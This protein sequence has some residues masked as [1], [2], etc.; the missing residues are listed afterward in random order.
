LAT[1]KDRVIRQYQR[2]NRT[3][4]IPEMA[5][6]TGIPRK[7]LYSVMSRMVK[8]GLLKRPAPTLYQSNPTIGVGE[9]LEPWRIQNLRLIATKM[10]GVRI[11]PPPELEYKPKVGYF[12]ELV[13]SGLGGGERDEVRLQF[14]I[15]S[16][17]GKLTF[18]AK[19]PLG[20]DLYGLQFAMA[21]L[22][23]ECIEHGFG[24]KL[25]WRADRH[26]EIFKD[27]RVYDMDSLGA[28]FVSRSDY[29]GWMEKVYQKKYGAW[30]KEVKVPHQTSLESI[31]AILMGGLS[32]GQMLNA[33]VKSLQNQETAINIMK[34]MTGGNYDLQ[35]FMAKRFDAFSEV[36][37]KF[38]E[39]FADMKKRIGDL[40]K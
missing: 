34:G 37:Y 24:G 15:G 17:R 11:V 21:W 20:L 32:T 7:S 4:T 40:E 23:R 2:D 12:T 30:R 27:Q 6:L 25:N 38:I 28:K 13:L 5:S 35:V 39:E 16:K 3:Y 22:D 1:Y 19:A 14:Q 9:D 18:T 29:E 31:E 26:T 8:E 36:M 33:T 10:D